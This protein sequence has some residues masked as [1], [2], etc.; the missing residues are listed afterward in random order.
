[1]AYQPIHDYGIIGDMNSCA[2]VSLQGSIDWACF[3]RFD[4]PSIF[5]AILDDAKGGR[6]SITVDAEY[7]VEQRYLPDSVV[8]ETTFTCDTGSA[9]VLDFMPQRRLREKEA[10]HEIVRIVRGLR[11]TVPMRLVFQPR[12][13]YARGATHL[14]AERNGALATH[15]DE[16]V[17]LITHLPLVI[18]PG[19][20]GSAQAVASFTVSEGESWPA[21]A[22]Y[23]LSRAPSVGSMDAEAK[24]T[25]TLRVSRGIASKVEY[26]GMWHDDV[27]R[28]F[29]TLHL[30]TYEPTGAVVAAPTTSLPESIGGPRNWDYRYSWL[31]DSAWTVG[32]LFRLGDPHEGIAFM[33]WIVNNCWLGIE[34]MQVLY[35]ITKQSTLNEEVLDHLEGYRGSAPVRIGNDAASHRQLDVFGE[36]ALS[37]EAYHKHHGDLPKTFWELLVRIADLAAE[38]WPLPDRGI[39]EVRGPEQHFVYSKLMCWVALD[40]AVALAKVYGYDENGAVERWSSEAAKVRADILEHGWSETKQSFTQAYGTDTMDASALLMCFVGFLPAGDSRLRSTVKRIQQEL[41]SGPFVRRYL[42]HETDDG[43]SGGEGAFY[44]LSFWL[45]GAL[46]AVGEVEE[47]SAKFEEVM[48]TRNHLGLFA[49]MVDPATRTGLG[50]FPQAFSHIGFIHAARNV[51]ETLRTQRSEDATSI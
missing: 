17:A 42:T 47:A 10:P 19:P 28:S 29:L 22:A 31:R 4:S 33:E 38:M 23:G 39:W 5:A 30:L 25:R 15:G 48:A 34:S 20:D 44:I 45:I 50:N 14:A 12:M 2:L 13:D 1:M 32:I 36:L 46:L 43:L 9:A 11:G 21:I 24:L 16:S 51:S 49:E 3:P 18:E 37:L 26:D 27:V 8:I 6:F 41:A 40:R 35:G 7:T